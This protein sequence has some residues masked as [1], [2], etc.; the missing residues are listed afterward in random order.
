MIRIERDP[1]FWEAV[2]SHPA[3][4]GVLH[5]VSPQ[6][7]GRIAA[8]PA[9]LPMAAAHGGFLFGAMDGFGFV[10]ELHTLFTPE[11]WGREAITA[12][13]E[14]LNLLFEGPCQAVA[15][16][17]VGD[18]PRSRPPRRFG[19][20]VAGEFCETPFGSLRL[21]L[22]TRVAWSAAPARTRAYH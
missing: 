16:Y 7:V 12:G 2:A 5:G 20:A 21:W 22:L 9:M 13:I 14:A 1:A 6:M 4:E 8:M 10:R 3:L 15:T 11:G 18:N 19:F 17:E